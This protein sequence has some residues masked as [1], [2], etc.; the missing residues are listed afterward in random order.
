M[1]LK[2]VYISHILFESLDL[3]F[4]I[5]MPIKVLGVRCEGAVGV[6]AKNTQYHG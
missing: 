6:S 5:L 2:N 1:T 4:C 3:G